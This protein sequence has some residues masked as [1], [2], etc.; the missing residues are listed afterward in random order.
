MRRAARVAF[1]T[2]RR[3]FARSLVKTFGVGHCF[4]ATS[5]VGAACRPPGRAGLLPPRFQLALSLGMNRRQSA[6]ACSRSRERLMRLSSSIRVQGTARSKWLGATAR[7]SLI[8]LGSMI[9][10]PPATIPS[11]WHVGIGFL[12]SIATSGSRAPRASVCARPYEIAPPPP[13]RSNWSI[14]IR[15]RPSERTRTNLPARVGRRYGSF[16]V[17][18]AFGIAEGFTS[19]PCLPTRGTIMWRKRAGSRSCIAGT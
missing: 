5:A 6:L 4:V 16:D 14:R 8:S 10:R 3:R 11:T 15:R 13:F 18:R 12:L 9:S 19:G 17:T 2:S 1:C 7:T